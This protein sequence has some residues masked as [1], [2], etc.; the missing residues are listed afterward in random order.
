MSSLELPWAHH[1]FGVRW[2]KTA[3][4]VPGRSA[5]DETTI[6]DAFKGVNRLWSQRG[7]SKAV[8]GLLRAVTL[9][10]LLGL[11]PTH[12]LRATWSLVSFPEHRCG[13]RKAGEII[14]RAAGVRVVD[15]RSRDGRRCERKQAQTYRFRQHYTLESRV[16]LLGIEY[17]RRRQMNGRE[18]F[19]NGCSGYRTE[20]RSG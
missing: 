16:A 5:S 6:D 2:P 8:G 12:I 7:T 14:I 17:T 10:T 20:S 9:R 11:E 18:R 1:G 4:A 3:L 15:I 19:T 13:G